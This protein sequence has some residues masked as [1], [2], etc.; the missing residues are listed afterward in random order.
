[1][2]GDRDR[3]GI[4]SGV[5]IRIGIGIDVTLCSFEG[6]GVATVIYI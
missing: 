3:E 5:R 2:G 6:E 1:V 4:R